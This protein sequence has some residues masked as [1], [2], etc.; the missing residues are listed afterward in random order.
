MKLPIKISEE[1]A[2]KNR[3]KIE[4]FIFIV[5]VKSIHEE[6]LSQHL[7]NQNKQFKIAIAFLA[8]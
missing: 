8:G 3:T 7:Q 1:L 5:L 4:V 6:H 2:I